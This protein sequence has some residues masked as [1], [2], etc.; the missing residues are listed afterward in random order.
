MEIQT[1]TIEDLDQVHALYRQEQ[2]PIYDEKLLR[3]LIA[4][5]HWV[6]VFDQENLIGLARYITDGCLT[7]FLCEIITHQA[8]RRQGIGR[9][10]IDEIF[11]RHPGLRMD[12][13]SDADP[14]YE[15]LRFR[16]LGNG[17]RRYNT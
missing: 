7:I 2:W 3:E 16:L 17:Y 5:S 6:G 10:M 4:C 9:A 1:I 14:F 15:G 11:K 8:H 12:A 13:I